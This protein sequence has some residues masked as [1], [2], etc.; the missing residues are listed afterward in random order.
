MDYL[1]MLLRAGP[2]VQGKVKSAMRV[3][4]TS[5]A[6]RKDKE[7]KTMNEHLFSPANQAYVSRIYGT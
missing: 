6:S 2:Q 3:R 5:L 4:P 1:R 7:F